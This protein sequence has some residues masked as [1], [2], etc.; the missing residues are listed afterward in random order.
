[1]TATVDTLTEHVLAEINELSGANEAKE[2]LASLL[3]ERLDA[4]PEVGRGPR[5]ELQRAEALQSLASV[6][7][8]RADAATA[9]DLRRQAHDALERAPWPIP[10]LARSKTH[11]CVS[12]S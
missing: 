8:D 6:A 5:I 4:I 7:L 10:T 3:L 2:R 12:P 1:M 11:C 9:L